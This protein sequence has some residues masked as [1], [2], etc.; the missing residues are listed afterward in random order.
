MNNIVASPKA[1]ISDGI[2]KRRDNYSALLKAS[3]TD[4]NKFESNA[5]MAITS[6]PEITKG[7]VSDESIFK[8]CNRAAL[9]GVM[10]DG[11][12]AAI[13][14]GNVKRG[15]KWYKEAQYRLMARGI[16][17]QIH[18]SKTIKKVFYHVIHENDK[19]DMVLTPNYKENPIKHVPEL[20]DRGEIIGAYAYVMY[21]D[22]D[23]SSPEF[24]TSKDIE[25]IRDTYGMATSKM[26][27]S[28]FDQACKK[29]ILHRLEKV[30]DLSDV[31]ID[32]SDDEAQEA[33]QDVT[34]PIETQEQQKPKKSSAIEE[35]KARAKVKVEPE[36]PLDT[37]VTDLTADYEVVTDED[38][39]I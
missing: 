1:S 14:I 36:L 15:D 19:I 32:I 10:L 4:I 35:A 38:L 9:A 25:S 29:T 6:I 20:K 23:Y 16:L 22:E 2:K 39:P 26:W 33:L 18:R 37:G 3:G 24:M 8:V 34:P 11:R 12:E 5:L 27:V 28:S 21:Y 13:V 7:E 17:K 30:L 31:T